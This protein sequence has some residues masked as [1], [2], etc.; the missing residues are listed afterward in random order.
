MIEY[1]YDAIRAT[2]GSAIEIAAKITDDTGA[3]ITSGVHFMLFN[4]ENTETLMV[5]DGDY[6]SYEGIWR[7]TINPEATRGKCGHYW[8]CI[9]YESNPLCFKSPFYL[10]K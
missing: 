10:V 6:D 4:Y 8:Y 2:A 5:V 3:L 7:F 1:L 9:C